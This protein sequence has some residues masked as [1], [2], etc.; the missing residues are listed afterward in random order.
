[1]EEPKP[2][3]SEDTT[4]ASTA[5]PEPTT[6]E[7]PTAEAE[8]KAEVDISECDAC[9]KALNVACEGLCVNGRVVINETA[10]ETVV[11]ALKDLGLKSD[12]D[13]VKKWIDMAADAGI[14]NINWLAEFLCKKAGVC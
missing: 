4:S 3:T 11:T 2:E 12:A 13:N 6:E 10:T 8:E 5:P 7:Q 14:T 9:R 1:M